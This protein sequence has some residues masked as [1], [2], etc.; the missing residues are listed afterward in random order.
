MWHKLPYVCYDNIYSGVTILNF[1]ITFFI[2]IPG[3]PVKQRYIHSVLAAAEPTLIPV[4]RR[5]RTLQCCKKLVFDPAGKTVALQGGAG[6][7]RLRIF[8]LR[9]MKT[10][11]VLLQSSAPASMERFMGHSGMR[12]ICASGDVIPI[13]T[14]N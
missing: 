3:L 11:E 13:R 2:G 1:R 7:S 10:G 12:L 8:D 6:F 14:V 9:G 4:D 5:V